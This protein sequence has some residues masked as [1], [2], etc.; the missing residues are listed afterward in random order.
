MTQAFPT[1][2]LW[3]INSQVF[4][5]VRLEHFGRPDENAVAFGIIGVEKVCARALEAYVSVSVSQL[6][7]RPPFVVEIGAVGL[8]GVYMG[9]PHPEFRSGHYYGPIHD[10]TLIRRFELRGATQEELYDE[11]RHFFDELY[12][13]AE[14][15]RSEIL[16]DEHIR[17]NDLPGRS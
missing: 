14:C 5:N 9:A 4:Q 11:L 10:D 13:L 3:G 2:E 15:S 16:T 6:K 1:G 17:R 7:L 8:R 12:D